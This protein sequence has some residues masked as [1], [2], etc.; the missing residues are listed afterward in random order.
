MNEPGSPDRPEQGRLGLDRPAE[1][2]VKG[3]EKV[4]SDKQEPGKPFVY[5]PKPGEVWEDRPTEMHERWNTLRR[6]GPSEKGDT[7]K[8]QG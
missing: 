8:K 6:S 3:G 1:G 5:G 2:S 7:P 4:D